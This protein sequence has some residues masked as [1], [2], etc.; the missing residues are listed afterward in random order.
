MK[1]L[2]PAY[3]E[4]TLSDDSICSFVSRLEQRPAFAFC[5]RD[6]KERHPTFSYVAIE[7]ENLRPEANASNDTFALLDEFLSQAH[8]TRRAHLPP[9]QGG[10]FAFF[11]HEVGSA[12]LTSGAWPQYIFLLTREFVAIDHQNQKA[13]LIRL[14]DSE[15]D[16]AYVIELLRH[17][18]SSLGESTEAAA[19]DE[20]QDF[21]ANWS[22]DTTKSAHDERV[23]SIQKL[24]GTSTLEQAILS[25]GMSRPFVGDTWS[26]FEEFYSRNPSQH[27]YYLNIEGF[28]LVGSTPLMFLNVTDGELLVETDA[29][30]RPLGA[31]QAE[32]EALAKDLMT[33]QKDKDEQ[34][35]IVN[36]T[37][38]DLRRI[39]RDQRVETPVP[40][41]LRMFSHVMHLY[42]IFTAKLAAGVTPGAAVRQ[43]FP[44][45]A[46]SGVPRKEALRAYRA[47]EG[48]QRGPYGGVIGLF[49]YGGNIDSAVVIRSVW[50]SEGSA[51]ARTGGG[52]IGASDSDSEFRECMTKAAIIWDCVA[53]AEARCR[54]DPAVVDGRSPGS[55]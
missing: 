51:H 44:S 54:R 47:L 11:S 24:I 2:V 31:T 9:F 38:A 25:I 34:R 17:K 8:L 39:A 27:A 28:C 32:S 5:R 41:E 21:G 50:F 35:L 29:G 48:M 23:R 42:T 36:A 19:I 14:I 4:F 52:I 6:S 33:A 16:E 55:A 15:D 13:F 49:E 7:V 26:V 12:E 3:V 10:V 20:V 22:F 53:A 45:P 18:V 30:T 40:L 37:I 1:Q 43:C 46:V